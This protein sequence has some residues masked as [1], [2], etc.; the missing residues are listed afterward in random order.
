ML[1]TSSP[2]PTENVLPVRWEGVPGVVQ[3]SWP[4]EHGHGVEVAGD[5]VD[6]G[7]GFDAGGR[8]LAT[9]L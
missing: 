7:H 1:T 6:H 9:A 3:G 5:T 2:Q 8:S 4:G